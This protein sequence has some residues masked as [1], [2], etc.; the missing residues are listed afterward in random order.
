MHDTSILPD[1]YKFLVA[2]SCLLASAEKKEQKIAAKKRMKRITAQVKRLSKKLLNRQAKVSKEVGVKAQDSS[3]EV[4][5]VKLASAQVHEWEDHPC[6]E[7][8][9]RGDGNCLYR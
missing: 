9:I 7:K 3:I 6:E 2:A 5:E 1:T 8:K 4:L